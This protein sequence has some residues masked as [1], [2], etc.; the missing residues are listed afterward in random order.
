MTIQ[1][2]TVFGATGEQGRHQ[3]RELLKQ[4][5]NVRVVSRNLE[6]LDH[7]DFEGTEKVVADFDDAASV[8]RALA[9]VD[10]IFYQVKSFVPPA[11]IVAQTETVRTAAA[12]AGV[13][14]IIVNSSMWAPDEPS[15]KAQS[16]WVLSDCVYAME[17]TMMAGSVPVIVL[18]PTLFMSNLLGPWVA[19]S[20][21]NGVYRYCHK[22]N[23]LADWICLE[24]VAQFMVAALK[25]PEF[26]GQKIMIGGPDRLR[27]LEMVELIGKAI[28]TDLRFE[29]V[30]PRAF[31][32]EFWNVAG[33][34]LMLPHDEFVENFARFYTMNNEDPRSPFQ[35]DVEAALEL[36][37]EVTLT[38]MRDWA[39]R[40][41]WS[42]S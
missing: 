17:E 8:D 32:E 36:F 12:K 3:P 35:A 29:Y 13:Q 31:A 30:P 10:A 40:Q 16:E 33:A 20:L 22:P 34:M 38:S 4:G 21:R 15:D 37:P 39:A 7:P 9:G 18:R 26:A 1:T 19:D 42:A 11:V 28:E 14:L 41:N 5:Y 23:L 6:R 27:T 24:D 2:V 25:K